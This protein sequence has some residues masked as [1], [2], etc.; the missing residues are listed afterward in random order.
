MMVRIKW[1]AWWIQLQAPVLLHLC[2]CTLCSITLQCFSVNRKNPLYLGWL[3]WLAL[4]NRVRWKWWC[5]SSGSGIQ[6]SCVSCSA[7]CHYHEN[8]S[9]PGC[10]RMEVWG[11]DKSSI[12][13][14]PQPIPRYV[15]NPDKGH[16]A[17]PPQARVI[18]TYIVH[19]SFCSNTLM[20]QNG[21]KFFNKIKEC[22]ANK[23]T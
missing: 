14:W 9:Q 1:A 20:L 17:D 16:L 7:F 10:W 13:Q 11:R 12:T 6:E 22:S 5:A 4:A 21:L 19:H 8:M 3:C 15:S 2:I 23:K 18:K